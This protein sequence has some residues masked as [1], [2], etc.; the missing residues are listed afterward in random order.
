MQLLNRVTFVLNKKDSQPSRARASAEKVIF[1]YQHQHFHLW[2]WS[3]NRVPITMKDG[4]A[5]GGVGRRGRGAPGPSRPLAPPTPAQSRSSLGPGR[6]EESFL[7]EGNLVRSSCCA[8]LCS[9]VTRSHRTGQLCPEGLSWG[10]IFCAG[11]SAEPP[12]GCAHEH[13]STQDVQRH[14]LT[15]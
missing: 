14:V 8:R 9:R 13:I 12:L 5:E 7:G 11:P 4:C 6:V 10:G 1:S 2:N 3:V 15:R